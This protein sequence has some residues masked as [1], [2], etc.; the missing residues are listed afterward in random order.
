MELRFIEYFRSQG[1]SMHT[2]RKSAEKARLEWDRQ[3]PFALSHARYLTDR[4]KIF[5]QVA[6]DEGDKVTWDLA[7][8]Q[9]E[10]W[11]AIEQAVARGVEFNPRTD[12]ACRWH[13]KPGDFPLIVV[14][15]RLAYGRPVIEPRGVPTA[16]L[17][18]QWKAEKGDAGRVGRWFDVPVGEVRQAIEFELQIAV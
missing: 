7:S 11:E 6:K 1:V 2:L 15:P 18:R 8:G 4:R 5:A 10:F 16:A 14:D 17:F 3:H 9:H 12:L 13:P